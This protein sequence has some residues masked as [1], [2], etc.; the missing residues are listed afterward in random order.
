MPDFIEIARGRGSQWRDD[1]VVT[2][3][4]MLTVSLLA[5]LT[6]KMRPGHI[7]CY[8]GCQLDYSEELVIIT[9]GNVKIIC[10]EKEI[11]Q[12]RHPGTN[13]I[14]QT[15]SV[16]VY[17]VGHT[18]TLSGFK[19]RIVTPPMKQKVQCTYIKV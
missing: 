1:Q 10:G 16:T 19:M 13:H 17:C 14:Q 12:H 5:I 2:S 4:R 18:P 8:Y 6:R 7:S 15:K 3:L 9:T 11:D